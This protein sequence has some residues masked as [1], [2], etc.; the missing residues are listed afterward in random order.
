VKGLVSRLSLP[1]GGRFETSIIS[2]LQFISD[3]EVYA[4]LSVFTAFVTFSALLFVVIEGWFG[5]HVEFGFIGAV[6]FIFTT[7]TTVG[8]GDVVP[9]TI[10][11]SIV[12]VII[13]HVGVG[14]CYYVFEVTTSATLSWVDSI[15][16]I[17]HL[18]LFPALTKST[19]FRKLF[20][21]VIIYL[22]LVI[23]SA[24]LF[25]MLETHHDGNQWHFWQGTWFSFVTLTTM[26]Y[27][28][29]APKTSMGR[30]LVVVN[31]TLGFGMV[32][33]IFGSLGTYIVK[34]IRDWATNELT[35]LAKA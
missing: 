9:Q 23:E 22:V 19:R 27:G 34:L 12:N 2:V 5:G 14:L 8:Y 4:A 1:K 32:V 28:D 35:E 24:I 21:A 10:L 18:N 31:G 25:G 13:G 16:R 3:S 6:Y 20:W 7:I 17:Q 15:T 33:F 30:L 26:G 11:G 29:F